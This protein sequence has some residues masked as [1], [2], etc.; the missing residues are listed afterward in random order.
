LF[1]NLFVGP[2]HEP[3]NLPHGQR[4]INSWSKCRIKNLSILFFQGHPMTTTV[5]IL[6]RKGTVLACYSDSDE[7]DI[8][9]LDFDMLDSEGDKAVLD[10]ERRLEEVQTEMKAVY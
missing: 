8:E 2:D 7:V 3:Q 9:L 1:A 5:V 6:V 4:S 10:G